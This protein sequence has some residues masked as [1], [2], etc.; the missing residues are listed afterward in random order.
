MIQQNTIYALVQLLDDMDCNVRLHAKSTLLDYGVSIIPEIEQ[1]EE[2]CLEQ[3]EQLELIR[4]LLHSLRFQR[5]KTQIKDWLNGPDKDL[6][7]GVFILCSY[8]YPTLTKLEFIRKFQM[9]YHRCW[10]KIH[11]KQTNFEKISA[12]NHIF[13][14]EFGFVAIDNAYYSPFDLLINAVLDVRE[15]HPLA[16][17]L[18]YCLVAQAIGLPVYGVVNQNKRAPFVLA[19]LDTHQLL[20]VLNWGIDNNGVLFYIDSEQNGAILE[21]LLLKQRF[22]ELGLS[23]NNGIFS[24]S[25]HSALLLHYLTE[26]RRS[27]ADV[28]QF[29]YKLEDLDE[30]ITLFNRY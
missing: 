13:F 18:I 14:Q 5:I 1:L 23:T 22:S 4:E 3:P 25:S 11:P 26:I 9:L 10:T 6:M 19:Y 20:P 30:L 29:R 7:E 17:G 21:P 2:E 8:Q 24:P 15:G 28:P 27:C 16:I 12:F